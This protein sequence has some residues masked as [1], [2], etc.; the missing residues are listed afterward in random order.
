M[1]LD[2]FVAAAECLN[3][4]V[5]LLGP[6]VLPGEPGLGGTERIVVLNE[7]RRELPEF[8]V[9]T[10]QQIVV[11]FGIPHV[12]TGHQGRPKTAPELVGIQRMGPGAEIREPQRQTVSLVLQD[13]IGPMVVALPERHCPAQGLEI[14]APPSGSTGIYEQLRVTL[15][16]RVQE[17]EITLN[18]QVL[19]H[20]LPVGRVIVPPEDQRLNVEV[21]PVDVDAFLPDEAGEQLHGPLPGV[22]ISEIDQSAFSQR[23]NLVR[24][25]LD[26]RIVRHR[27]EP[28]GVL[29]VQH[30]VG[31][32]LFRFKP[33]EELLPVGVRQIAYRAQSLRIPFAVCFPRGDESFVVVF[34]GVVLKNPGAQDVHPPAVELDLL[35]GVAIDQRRLLLLVQEF[36][37]PAQF[38]IQER[39]AGPE[40]GNFLAPGFGHVVGAHPPPPQVLRLDPA[41]ALLE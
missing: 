20:P 3:H 8:V 9:Q 40:H 19:G 26:G 14:I 38:F 33:D 2:G 25:L 22:R 17:F 28:L 7:E 21:Q 31:A 4:A 13:D 34:V 30:V 5:P 36:H 16:K 32:N 11:Q 10:T 23:K 12:P 37:A 35:F 24:L 15:Q 18:V 6:V 27:Q 41:A 39:A 29:L 1:R